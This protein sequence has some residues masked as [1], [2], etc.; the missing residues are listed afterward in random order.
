[1]FIF[2]TFHW[3]VLLLEVYPVLAFSS[4]SKHIKV[5][6]LDACNAKS[7]GVNIRQLYTSIDLVVFLLFPAKEK[8]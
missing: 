4:K 8:K 2:V 5:K 6:L 7:K 1:M 3:P